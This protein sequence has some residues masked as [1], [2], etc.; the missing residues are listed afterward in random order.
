MHVRSLARAAR[1]LGTITGLALFALAAPFDAA[2]ANNWPPPKGADMKDPNN[3]PNDPSYNGMWNYFSFLPQQV[4]GTPPYVDDDVTLG[5]SGMHVDTAWQYTIG[6]PDIRIAILDS[7]IEWESPDIV[8]KAYLNAGELGGIKRPQDKN[9]NVCGG[10]GMVAGYDCDGDGVFTVAD[11]RDDPRVAPIVMGDGCFPNA[12]P[13]LP[14][15]PRMKGD[16]NHNCIFDAG[17]LIELFSDGVDDD[18]NGYKDDISGWDFYKNDNNPYDDPRYGHGTGEAHDSSAE[19]NNMIESL[20]VCPLCRFM[21]LRAGDSFIADVNDFAKGVVYAADN[22]V[23]VIQEALGTIDQSAFSKAAIDYAYSK[24]TIV[25]AS[26]ADEN[27]RHHNVP[28]VANHTLPV[29]AITKDGDMLYTN[30]VIQTKSSTFIAFNTCTNFGA[31]NMM[32]ISGTACSSEAT[33]RASGAAGLMFSEGLNKGMKL[34][35]EEVMQ[36]FKMTADVINVPESRSP[37]PTVAGRFYESLPGFSQRFGYGRLNLES[38]MQ[39]IDAGHIP[40]EV[41]LTSPAWFD[42][43]YADRL[44]AP[45]AI[46]GSVQAKRA[47]SY[48]YR[49]EWAPGVEPDDSA[50]QPLADWVR[51]VPAVMTTGGPMMPLAMLSP[52]Q[53]D[54]SHTPDPDSPHHENDRTITLR[55]VAIAHYAGSDMRGE[56][57]RAIAIV[58]EGNG[59]DADLAQGFPMQLGASI[60]SSP[61]LADI[62]G[63]GIRDL[64]VGASD[65]KLHVFSVKS[66]SPVEI[67]GFPYATDLLDGLNPNLTSEPSVPSY[68]G[69]PAY[70]NGGK[71]GGIDPSIAREAIVATPAIADVNGDGL[72]EIVVSTWPGTIHVIGHDGKPLAGWPKRLPLIPSCP[73]DP[74]KPRP[75]TCMDT[76][77]HWARG[78]G[79]SPVLADFLHDGKL[80]IVQAAFDGNIYVFKS[81]ATLLDGYP[82][83]LHDTHA[84]AYNRI[85]S[86]PALSDFNGDGIPDIVC[87]SNEE[88]GAG[89]G[90]GP[91]FMVD[92]RGTKTP[93]GNPYFKDWPVSLLSLHLLPIVG[94]GIDTAPAVADFTGDGKPDVLLQGNASPPSVFPVDPGPQ[95]TFGDVANAPHFCQGQTVG[96]FCPT[97]IFGPNSKATAPDTMFPLFS[98]PSIGDLDQDGVPD[99]IL[100]GGS[101]SL[102]ANLGGGSSA[103]PFQHLLAAWTP[104]TGAMLPGM[105]VVLE[106]YVFLMNHAVADINGDNYPEVVLGTG[107]YFV[108]AVDAC[109]CEASGW[110]KFTD[111]WIIATPAVGDVDGDHRLEVVAGTR[112]GN[113]FA[114]HTHGSDTGVIAW[115]SYHHDNANTGDYG[116]KLDQGVLRLAGTPIDCSMDCAAPTPVTTPQYQAGGCACRSGAGAGGGMGGVAYGVALA[117]GLAALLFGRRRKPGR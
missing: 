2:H 20:G 51:N 22:G 114:W 4:A 56:A 91:V 104:T 107:G 1:A 95:S 35:P 74:S 3:W 63:D 75:M 18:A 41:D 57:R 67:P 55:V 15:Q 27:S 19:G 86:T 52:G 61:K 112:E 32:S 29:H 68:L 66:G 49:V 87:G 88:L 42:V 43:L 65:G 103:Q 92:G 72:P 25:I 106:D 100:S 76:A 116:R 40:P 73:L 13:M 79:S 84:N 97:S 117:G 21:M 64:V 9:G 23:N 70:T 111:G 94:E 24:G 7:G 113:L 80:E 62:D 33:G 37:D 98:C 46:M 71:G 53:I 5:A 28:G 59:L 58:N 96:T 10:Q 31:Q 90:A 78:A 8:N 105:P 6:R 93:G 17:D 44:S 81:D 101:L 39:A 30:G 60:E 26:M 36:L 45:V 50:F 82:V 16:V 109:G 108:R 115:E 83:L 69:A 85:L 77:H 54:T 47:Q 89:G 11:Y 34:S 102:A 12:N 48:D 38:A 14:T 99:A 110:P